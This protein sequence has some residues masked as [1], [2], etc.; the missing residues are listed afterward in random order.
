M[1]HQK[2]KR[3]LLVTPTAK[4]TWNCRSK[5]YYE[6]LGYVFTGVGTDLIVMAEDLLP[7]SH[8]K[9]HVACDRCGSEK[10]IAYRD[11]LK[12]KTENYYCNACANS[13]YGGET[14]R[15]QKLR[16]EITFKEYLESLYGEDAVNMYLSTKNDVDWGNI[17]YRSTKTIWVKCVNTNE[18][19]DYETS[20]ERFA[21]GDRCAVCGHKK[22]HPSISLAREMQNVFGNDYMNIWSDNNVRGPETYLKSDLDKVWFRC[23]SGEHADYQRSVVASVLCGFECP[24]C[25]EYSSVSKLATSVSDYINTKHHYKTLHENGCTIYPKNPL[26]GYHLRYDNEIAELGLIIEVHGSQHYKPCLFTEMA[27]SCYNRSVEEEFAYQQWKDQYKKDYAIAHGYSY[28]EIPYW[29]EKDESYKTLI[30]D[31]ISAAKLKL[32]SKGA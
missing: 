30:D 12:R 32:Q 15:I 22:R 28:L 2:E 9:I 31:A 18:H 14:R 27:A 21:R 23:A 29:T 20:P 11:Y 25:R 5:K 10:H 4:L 26:T 19:P 24:S 13:L 8:V 6:S 1:Y 17:S 7:T 16:G 3:I